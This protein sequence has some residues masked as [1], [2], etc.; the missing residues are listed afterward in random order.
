M[1]RIFQ[2]L[3]NSIVGEDREQQTANGRPQVSLNGAR[4]V[5]ADALSSPQNEH[6]E[7]I[8]PNLRTSQPHNSSRNERENTK[9]APDYK[10]LYPD[11]SHHIQDQSTRSTTAD[12]KRTKRE[13]ESAADS[14]RRLLGTTTYVI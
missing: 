5:L 2:T 6:V 11:V 12:P 8:E 9:P 1:T 4:I 7:N 14:E 3:Y 10:N 13:R